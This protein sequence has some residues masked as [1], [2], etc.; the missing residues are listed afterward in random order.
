MEHDAQRALL[1]RHGLTVGDLLRRN[2]LVEG[3]QD[4][5]IQMRNDVRISKCEEPS[6]AIAR[7]CLELVRVEVR[8]S[9][10]TIATIW[11]ERCVPDGPL[12]ERVGARRYALKSIY[13]EDATVFSFQTHLPPGIVDDRFFP[14]TGTAV[15]FHNT[16]RKQRVLKA[17][18]S[19]ENTGVC[20]SWIFH[21]IEV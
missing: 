10:M 16:G 18:G 4:F 12:V 6:K 21:A 3:E 20:Q 11:G 1:E 8:G 14:A 15:L 19:D 5:S 17:C 13:L 2:D 7:G 9:L